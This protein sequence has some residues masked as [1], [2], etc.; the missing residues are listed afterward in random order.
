MIKRN[1]VSVRPWLLVN[2]CYNRRGSFLHLPYRRLLPNLFLPVV[3]IHV[4]VK[5]LLKCRTLMMNAWLVLSLS[6]S[7]GNRLHPCILSKLLQASRW[8][9]T[10]WLSHIENALGYLLLL[11][12]SLLLNRSEKLLLLLLV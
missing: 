2:R 11:P 5:F 10:A 3:N 9:S 1:K 7:G 8:L 12:R 4:A 6:R